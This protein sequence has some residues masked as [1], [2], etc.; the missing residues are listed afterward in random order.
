MIVYHNRKS[1]MRVWIHRPMQDAHNLHIVFTVAIPDDMCAHC[2]AA[3]S[4]TYIIPFR[5][6]RRV[7][8]QLFEQA[9]Q[10]IEVELPLASPP[11]V[12]CVALNATQ[13]VRRRVR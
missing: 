6:K 3:Q 5:A 10:P 1:Q 11:L 7:N 4:N 9:V 12:Q 8:P 2:K 13:V